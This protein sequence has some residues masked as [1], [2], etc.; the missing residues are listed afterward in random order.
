MARFNI[1]LDMRQSIDFMSLAYSGLY[2]Y[3]MPT[4]EGLPEVIRKT[5][6]KIGIGLIVLTFSTSVLRNVLAVV[7]RE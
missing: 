2:L 7:L 4:P 3:Q 6:L 5:L 1:K